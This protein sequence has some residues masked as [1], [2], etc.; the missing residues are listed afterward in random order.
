MAQRLPVVMWCKN[1]VFVNSKAILFRRVC[2]LVN[3]AQHSVKPLIREFDII[4]IN[5]MY[6]SVFS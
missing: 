3:S 6:M 1:F 5:S 4:S 2:L